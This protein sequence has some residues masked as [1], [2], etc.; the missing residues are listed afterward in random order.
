M[1]NFAPLRRL[2]SAIHRT[3]NEGLMYCPF[4]LRRGD[5]G[6]SS[7][8][9]HHAWSAGSAK[10]LRMVSPREAV[11]VVHSVLPCI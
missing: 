10:S 3:S 8:P 7:A 6:H 5:P 4:L 2:S 11:A 1:P 9:H